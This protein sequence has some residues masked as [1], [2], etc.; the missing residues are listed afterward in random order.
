[1]A[2]AE[3]SDEPLA[4][5]DIGTNSIHLLIARPRGNT[6]FGV[7]DR[8]KEMVRLGSGSGDMKL[9][10]PDAM[11][12][13]LDAL[14]RFK[15]VAASRDAHVY[16]VATSAGREA[17]NRNESLRERK[18]EPG[19]HIAVIPG[20]EEAQQIPLDPLNAVPAYEQRHYI[21]DIV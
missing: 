15:Q 11:E 12:R 7:I 3:P 4:A 8:E 14:R 20:A 17:E 2:R 21:I 1:M 9:L 16:A 5:I 18:D 10:A 6:R 13:G 19:V